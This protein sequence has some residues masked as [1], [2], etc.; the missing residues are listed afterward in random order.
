MSRIPKDI[1]RTLHADQL[2]IDP[3]FKS[4]LKSQL[5]KGEHQM[6]EAKTS[7]LS[8]LTSNKLL[9]IGAMVLALAFVGGASALVARG[10]TRNSLNR[11]SALPDDLSGILS[12]DAIKAKALT[13][14]PAG[15]T[16]SSIELENEDIGLIYKVR[17]SDS[18]FKLYNAKTGELVTNTDD[19]DLEIDDSVPADFVAGITIEKARE[20]AQA[21]R[22]GKTVT[23]IELETEDGKVV[24]SVRFSD[25]GR[26][27]VSATDGSVVRVKNESNSGPGSNNSGS[28][29]D[30][31]DDD[32]SEDDQEDDDNSEEEDDNSGS[33][34]GSGGGN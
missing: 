26:V 6:S 11:Q 25:G 8:R 15:T 14:A 29:N 22:P 4:K 1:S 21:Q 34:S 10:Q 2:I 28:G 9:P 5:F 24:Y 30:S 20:I 13:D 18:S 7:F 32:S 31:D 27:D 12:L 33:N 17:Y 19:D 16:L 23:K 3:K